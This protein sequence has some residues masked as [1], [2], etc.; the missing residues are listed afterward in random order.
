MYM[1]EVYLIRFAMHLNVNLARDR[2]GFKCVYH[3][4]HSLRINIIDSLM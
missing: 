3:E 4:F 1:F 2:F